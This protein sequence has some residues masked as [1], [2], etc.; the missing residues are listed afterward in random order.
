VRGD[1]IANSI[2]EFSNTQGNEGWYQGYRNYTADGRGDN[3]NA[4]TDFIPFP[5]ET[6]NGT[7]FD[8][9]PAASGP[10]TELYAESSHPN[11]TNSGG[12]EHWV[13]RR[14]Q[15][16][17][18]T[19]V[20]PLAVT[21]S[22]R[23]TNPGCGPAAGTTASLHQNGVLRDFEAV[24]G[25]D[26][27]GITR[28]FYLNVLPGDKIDLALTPVSLAG[29]RGDGCDGSAFS[30][31]VDTAIPANPT[32]P[33]GSPFVPA[34]AA[35]TDADGLPDFWE[36]TFFPGDLTQLS[37]TGDKDG[38]GLND[39]GE[40]ARL[41]SP[42]DTDTDDDGL[43]DL[44]ETKTGIY[45]SPTNTGSS[46][47]AADSDGDGLSDFAEV[48]ATPPTNPNLA[49]TDGDSFSDPAERFF[50]SDPTVAGDTPLSF[51]I[52]NSAAE[53]SGVQRQDG[54]QNGYRDFTAT[55]RT[56][57][58]DP[59]TAF[60]PFAGGSDD[61]TPYDGGIE[62]MQHW[63]GTKW[64]LATPAD[65]WTE[66]LAEAVHP[67]GT[68][69]VAEHWAIRRWQAAELS[70]PTPVALTWHMRKGNASDDGVTGILFVNGRQVDYR[71]I[72]GND[73]V[74]VT[75]KVYTVIKP[76][77]VV[78]L[79]LTPTGRTQGFDYA[80]GSANWL[81]VDTRIPTGA[82]QP[83]GVPFFPPGSPDTD[84]DGLADAWE[85]HY[86]PGPLTG[87]GGGA[88]DA[89]SDGLTNVREQ[90]VGTDPTRS[91][92]DGDGLADGVETMTGVVVGPG[93]TGSNP[94]RADSDE[95]GL[96]DRDEA[97]GPQ[98][99]T[100]PM[101]ADT[102]GDIFNDRTELFAPSDPTLAASTPNTPTLANSVA[103]FSGLQEN[104]N[105]Q[106]G[107][108]D[109]TADGGAPDYDP[110]TAFIPFAGGDG[111][112]DWNGAD[113]QWDGGAWRLS[114]AS[115][116]TTINNNSTHPN[117]GGPGEHWSLRRWV[118]ETTEPTPLA[119]RWFT[120]K[121]N[122]ACGDGVTG[123]VYLNG[124]RLDEVTIAFNDGTGTVRVYYANVGP[125]DIVDLVVQPD[126]VD[127][128]KTDGCDGTVSWLRID[129]QVPPDARQPDGSLFA[130]EGPAFIITGVSR[131]A[132]TGRVTLTWPS[133]AGD[134]FDVHY[135][136]TLGTGQWTLLSPAAG[137]TATAATTSFTDTTVATEAG[138]TH[139]YY[140]VTRR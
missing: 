102:D 18:V 26:T 105:W 120:G 104:N 31:V 76:T 97:L 49:D 87:L 123:A 42:V 47:I 108:R 20:T 138:S 29:D 137:V 36:E 75:R 112:G 69:G 65:P 45:V 39:A 33:D 115:P 127:G 55:G 82:T 136:R 133:S 28:T 11:G 126:G 58:Y 17:E 12:V 35:D 109:L 122:T 1:E 103:D 9:N 40:Y 84:G 73:G 116:W 50:G 16:D 34:S 113:Q 121:G 24:A 140:R 90:E 129:D 21:Y 30:M 95:D 51:V 94:R 78:D 93:D 48:T 83:D 89:D 41:S 53:F 117:N 6:W 68:N 32:Q 135:S 124:Q 4:V 67:N 56:M 81:R 10:W 96:S 92:T 3:Y 125:G 8:I 62:G 107:W 131:E 13:I 63:D 101:L 22:L 99:F 71:T 61:A 128:G 57:N 38:D 44:V 5:A 19:A 54:W 23:K 60:I 70:G 64:D 37:A 79:A 114:G 85:Q 110:D 66:L 100:N 15:A 80:D 43:G 106:Y 139:V 119:L 91:D 25:D 46:P 98:F 86:K 118:S 2:T 72:A 7:G 130:G 74:G 132:A 77:D 134:V 14:W 27:V 111:M 88:E 52:A 59:A